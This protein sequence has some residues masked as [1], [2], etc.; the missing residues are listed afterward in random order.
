VRLPFCD[1][2]PILTL[3]ALTG[4]RAHRVLDLVDEVYRNARRRISTG[5]LNRTLERIVAAHQPPAGVTHRPTRFYYMTQ[6][7]VAP[8]TFVAQV[9]QPSD[10]PESY[11]RYVVNQLR[12]IYGFEGTPIRLIVRKPRGRHRWNES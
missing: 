5:Q 3:S 2:A 9:N 4:Q 6:V 10:V 11:R 1:W 7:G 8:P 12:E